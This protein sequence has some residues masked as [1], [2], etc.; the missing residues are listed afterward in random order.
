MKRFILFITVIPGVMYLLMSLTY[1]PFWSVLA[2]ILIRGVIAFRWPAFS[3]YLNREI[4]DEIRA[5]TLSII[6]MLGSFYLVVMR[7][8]IGKI[9]DRSLSLAFVVMGSIII[10]ASIILEIRRRAVLEN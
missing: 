5:T 1:D 2:F 4:P 10:A 9:A 3:D 6:S 8:V 7:I